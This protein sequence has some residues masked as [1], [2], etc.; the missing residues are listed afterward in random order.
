MAFN[1]EQSQV[2]KRFE[3]RYELEQYI[4]SLWS[5]QDSLL[6][7]YRSIFITVQSIFIGIIF[8]FTQDSNIKLSYATIIIFI[9]LFTNIIWINLSNDRG[10]SVLYLQTL[11]RRYENSGSDMELNIFG[12]LRRFQDDWKFRKQEISKE[13]FIRPDATRNALNFWLPLVFFIFWVINSYSYIPYAA[14]KK[15]PNLIILISEFIVAV[16]LCFIFIL[17]NL[18]SQDRLWNLPFM[19]L[20]I[21]V[22]VTVYLA[23][24]SF[25]VLEYLWPDLVD[26]M[27]LRFP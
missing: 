25:P 20:L 4:V 18:F 2:A 11:L 16:L 10:L 23:S 7:S 8:A 14:E 21:G 22:Y 24:V 5:I 12:N 3:T 6:Q 27:L 17:L 26:L 1:R 9:G 19:S 15:D 13:D